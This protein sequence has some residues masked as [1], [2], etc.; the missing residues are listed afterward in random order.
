MVQRDPIKNWWKHQQIL[1]SLSVH[2]GMNMA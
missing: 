1:N 2:L